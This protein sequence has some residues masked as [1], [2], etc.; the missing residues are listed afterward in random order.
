MSAQIIIF[1][2]SHSLQCGNDQYSA[3]QIET[4]RQYV[5]DICRSKKIDFIAEEMISDSLDNLGRKATVAAGVA[6]RL[7]IKHKYIDLTAEERKKLYIDD[8]SLASA[9]TMVDSRLC[10]KQ[11]RNELTHKLACP[12][13]ECYWLAHILNEKS[14]PT[15]LICGADHVENMDKLIDSIGLHVIISESDYKP[16]F[17]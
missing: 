5:Y 12:V 4:F 8:E 17:E 16:L 13:R 6:K 14:W 1:G 2:T 9:A 7:D 15:L 3:K 11:L 10:P